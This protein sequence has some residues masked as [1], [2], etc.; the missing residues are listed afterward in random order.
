VKFLSELILYFYCV[1]FFNKLTRTFS[2][3]IS[4][5]DSIILTWK[6]KNWERCICWSLSSLS[7]EKE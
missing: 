4:V 2:L 6:L 3:T 1:E 7:L 5:L